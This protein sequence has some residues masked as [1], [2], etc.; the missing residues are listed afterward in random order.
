MANLWSRA[1][2]GAIYLLRGPGSV[3]SSDRQLITLPQEPPPLRTSIVFE[4]HVQEAGKASSRSKLPQTISSAWDERN[5]WGD[6][7]I[8]WQGLTSQERK[9]IMLDVYLNNP[10]VSAC[11]DVI[12]KRICSGG[13]TVE[14]IDEEGPDN[15]Q[16]LDTLNEFLL[17]INPDWDFLQ[18][19]RALIMDKLI[20]GEC[21]SELTWKNG[22]PWQL[23]K[24][25]CI[26]M[27]YKANR[28]GQ[29]EQFYQEMQWSR[30]RNYLDPNNI[31]R[32]WFPHPR[33]SIDPFAPAEK[34]S[35]AVLLDKKMMNWMRTFF[36]KGSK[37]PFSVEGVGDQ[38]EA[39]R[40]LQFFRQN[41][42]GEKNAH[43][44]FVTWGNAKLVWNSA[45][46]L[47]MDFSMGLDR[48]RTIVFAAF[49]VPPAAVSIIE[50]GNIG[51]GTGEDQDKS[52]IFN[53]CDPV[54]GAYLEKLNDRIVKRGFGITDY[55]IGLKYADYRSDESVAKVEDMRIKNG[56]RTVNEIRLE[57][58][59]KP[60][61]RGGDVP[62]EFSTKEIVPLQRL[63]E[64]AD[65]Q[66]QSAA[67][68]LVSAQAAADLAQTKAKQAKEPPEPVPPA[69]STSAQQT[70]SKNATVQINRKGMKNEKPAPAQQAKNAQGAESHAHQQA[71]E[72][73]E[74]RTGTH[75]QVQSGQSEKPVTLLD[76]ME[77][78]NPL[79]AN[80]WID[81]DTDAT[82]QQLAAEGVVELTWFDHLNSCDPCASNAGQTVKIGQTFNSGHQMIPAH[83]HCYCSVEATYANGQKRILKS[84]FD[85]PPVESIE[86]DPDAT[87][88]LKAIKVRK[89][90]LRL[91]EDDLWEGRE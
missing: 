60:Y 36:Q 34:V 21:Y 54:K 44:P 9:L 72:N 45:Q 61:K 90:A 86:D 35:D 22:Q 81:P 10:W 19:S 11:V 67:V 71:V 82:L 78:E 57:G 33:A 32:W 2:E 80:L 73:R 56:S 26:P 25:D 1:R 76:L 84:P 49:G 88:K 41:F 40:F 63:D 50:S 29:I 62:F 55:R 85:K 68:A 53:A 20:F 64:I 89:P 16:H 14:K 27:G 7:N 28:Y 69:L 59:K 52:L 42:T 65:E 23:F 48:M 77:D 75:G 87:Q 39:D 37:F 5:Q 58:G 15:Q 74:T 8:T 51:G 3:V 13:F 47:D 6:T 30:E 18:L 24:A 31:I 46:K 12:A 91:T 79:P 66:K 83:P 17:R 70:V 4:S 38:D 43:A